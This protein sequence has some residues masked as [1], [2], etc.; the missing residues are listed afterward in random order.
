MGILSQ[1]CGWNPM[2]VLSA[3]EVLPE[4]LAAALNKTVKDSQKGTEIERANLDV[5]RSALRAFDVMCSIPESMQDRRIQELLQQVLK[6][7]KLREMMKSE[8]LLAAASVV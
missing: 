8:G 2:A 1:L 5:I 7:E 6:K 4:P 3:T